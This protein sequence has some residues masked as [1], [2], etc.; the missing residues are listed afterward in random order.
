MI[1]WWIKVAPISARCSCLGKRS[2]W[3]YTYRP[4]APEHTSR[5]SS[6]RTRRPGGPFLNKVRAHDTPVIPDPMMRTSTCPGNNAV[7]V[8]DGK[9]IGGT[10]QYGSVGSFA[11]KP[12]EK[13]TLFW[14]VEYSA[15][16]SRRVA[17]TSLNLASSWPILW[18][19]CKADRSAGGMNALFVRVCADS[20]AASRGHGSS[21]GGG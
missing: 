18:T 17:I 10:V 21:D 20:R 2:G 15:S 7:L 3:E 6:T 16:S 4:V 1:Q 12:G 11:G 14:S 5:A 19:C 8:G 13:F 9:F